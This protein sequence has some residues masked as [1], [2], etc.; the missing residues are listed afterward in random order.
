MLSLTLILCHNTRILRT[1]PR[2]NLHND[3]PRNDL[4]P[5]LSELRPTRQPTT[6]CEEVPVISHRARSRE[7]RSTP[8][9]AV[10]LGLLELLNDTTSVFNALVRAQNNPRSTKHQQPRCPPTLKPH[11]MNGLLME[12]SG[13]K[14]PALLSLTCR[15]ISVHR[16]SA[17]AQHNDT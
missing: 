16:K 5:S 8:K 13:L 9:H 14:I 7:C 3:T 1:P 17:Q 12:T 6:H 11:P 4:P 10:L 2:H 15:R